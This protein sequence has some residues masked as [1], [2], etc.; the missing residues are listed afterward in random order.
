MN[1]KKISFAMMMSLMSIQAAAFSDVG[2]SKRNCGAAKRD[3]QVIAQSHCYS[4]DTS[5]KVTMGSCKK[6]NSQGEKEYRVPV[7]YKCLVQTARF[8]YED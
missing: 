8:D 1:L 6:R 2:T 3:A 7:Y 4:L 5:P